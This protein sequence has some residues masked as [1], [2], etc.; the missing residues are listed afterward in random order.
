ML[1]PEVS[2]T[3]FKKLTAA[4]IKELQSCAV[5][6]NGELLFIAIIPSGR[7]GMAI[8][9]DISIHAEYLAHRMNSTG[10]K[11]IEEVKV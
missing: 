5:T 4:Q 10:G 1:I 11:T 2:H 8:K 7:G 9:D 3:D 6:S